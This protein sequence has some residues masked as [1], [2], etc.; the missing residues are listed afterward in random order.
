MYASHAT[1]P[2]A[3]AY[4]PTPEEFANPIAF[5]RKI[6]PE[7][8]QYGICK[9]IPPPQW[10]VA[11]SCSPHVQTWL[12]G[13]RHVQY[14]LSGRLWHEFLLPHRGFKSQFATFKQN[15]G[16][17]RTLLTR[18]ATGALEFIHMSIWGKKN[19]ECICQN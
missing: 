18:L 4:Y 19:Y 12:W 6:Q 10:Y 8:E 3:P 7:A 9:I 13:A 2:H 5:I 14:C 1:I 11:Q 17:H 16:Q 15:S